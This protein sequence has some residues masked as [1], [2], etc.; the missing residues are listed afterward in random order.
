MKEVGICVIKYAAIPQTVNNYAILL[1]FE[2]QNIPF[3][4][5]FCFPTFYSKLHYSFT[6]FSIASLSPCSSNSITK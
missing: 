5:I 6:N 1:K 4:D 3:D 2:K